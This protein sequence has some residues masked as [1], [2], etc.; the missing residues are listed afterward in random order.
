MAAPVNRPTLAAI[1]NIHKRLTSAIASTL[2]VAALLAPSASEAAPLA[3]GRMPTSTGVAPSSTIVGG[4]GT[5]QVCPTGVQGP[6]QPTNTTGGGSS[7]FASPQTLPG[8]YQ[9]NVL[10]AYGGQVSKTQNYST[11]VNNGVLQ[12]QNPA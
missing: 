9:L 11:A 10:G 5:V 3:P 1:M 7:G 12:V 2:V 4:L 6:C 8:L